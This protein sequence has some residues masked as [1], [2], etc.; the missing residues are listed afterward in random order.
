MKSAKERQR[1][2]PQREADVAT[3]PEATAFDDADLADLPAYASLLSASHRGFADFLRDIT[4]S[5]P[6][7]PGARVV[8]VGC[9]DGTYARLFAARPEVSGVTA[10]DILPA[11]LRLAAQAG[12]RQPGA[13]I[14]WMCAACEELPLPDQSCDLAWS[15]Q[16]LMDLPVQAALAEMRRVVRPGGL[17]AILENDSLHQLLLPWPV[18]LELAVRQAELRAFQA[19]RTNAHKPYIARTLRTELRR[20][21]LQDIRQQTFACDVE[22]PLRPAH[23][24]YLLAYFTRLHDRIRNFLEA[25]TLA[26]FCRLTCPDSPDFLPDQ[27]DFAMTCLEVLASGRPAQ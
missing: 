8:D 4:D 20:A 21:G 16:C 15:A 6:L 26:S 27:P 5:I 12:A 9:G 1:K 23:R 24:D 7:P 3:A 17:V 2:A 19:E 13:P 11:Y 18:E 14:D 22:A 10:V 25:D